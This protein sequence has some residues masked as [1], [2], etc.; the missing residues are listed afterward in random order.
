M[1]ATPEMPRSPA[2]PSL[3]RAMAVNPEVI[4][5]R[6]RLM[7]RSYE[8]RH[9]Y[10]HTWLG[11]PI[12]QYPEDLMAMQELIWDVKPSV[13]VETGIAH[14]GSLIFYAS[15]LKL[16]GNGGRAI[17]VD[18]DIRGHNRS[19]IEAHAMAPIIEMV[20]GS[21]IDAQVVGDIRNRIDRDDRVMVVLDSNH[22]HDH[23][24]AELRLYSPFV[25]SG[26]YIVVF[27]TVVEELPSGMFPDRPWDH[28]DNPY[29]AVRQFL[30][31]SPQY[32]DAREVSD[33]LLLSVARGGYLRK[34]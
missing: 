8:Y 2:D 3:M 7:E 19:A 11:R 25:T 26:S 1:T 34:R 30:A 15:I 16:I 33:K 9:T 29:T 18:I 24:L 4:D 28:G 32:E 13:I 12:I 21:S 31:E 27:D 14:G 10:Q 5:L 23:V 22:T 20:Q 6:S 17:G